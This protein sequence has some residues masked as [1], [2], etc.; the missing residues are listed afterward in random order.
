[1]LSVLPL[2]PE[3]RGPD[4]PALVMF[5]LRGRCRALAL[6]FYARSC[7]R[8]SAETRVLS[9]LEEG[10]TASQIAKRHEV[11]LST[12]RTQLASIR[13]RTGARTIVDLIHT[14]GSLPPIMPA[15]LG[16]A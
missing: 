9:A 10:L 2:H 14:L 13:L 7:G 15:A 4:A 11:A 12:V 8:T 16:C 6:E 3:E 5:G 1:M